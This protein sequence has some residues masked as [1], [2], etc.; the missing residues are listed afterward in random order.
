[1]SLR[2][3]FKAT[4]IGQVPKEW[5]VVRLEDIVETSS[6]GT[7][8]RSKKEYYGGNIPWVKSGELKDNIIHDTEE[9][10]TEKGL[11]NSAAKVF[12]EGT[13][14]IAMYGATVGKTAILAIKATTNQAVCAILPKK[15]SFDPN[16]LR[17]YVIFRR[18][19]L[20]SI[21]SGGAQPN[22]SQEI[23]RSFKIPLPSLP[24]QRKIA[25][26]LFT[27]DEAIQWVD[28]AIARTERLKRGLIQRLL[29]RGIGRKEF[30]FSKELGHEIPKKW[31]VVELSNVFKLASGKTRPTKLFEN[32]TQEEMFPVYGGNG[33]LGY[34]SHYFVDKEVIVIGRVGEYCGAVYK[35]PKFSWITDNALY[36]TEIIRSE[37]ELNYLKY[38]LIYLNLNKFKKKSGQPLMT[39][40]IIY[41]I[42]I[43]LPPLPEQLKIA[44]ILSTVD[45]KIELERQRK[46]KLERIKKG[47]MN[48]LLTGKVRVKA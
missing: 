44:D 14:L 36:T 45:K 7:P 25:E 39:Q 6:G 3:S 41:S 5:K 9:K 28:E 26:I 34:T 37:I 15:D 17:D 2:S 12:P 43:P 18:A 10:I 42:Q 4:P 40:Q 22:I 38:L 33:I 13:L 1:M 29:T 19:Q 32:P 30:R 23:I 8:N 27:V 31:G 21:S 35:A 20:T 47:L 46:E 24:E 48:D 16:F 11:E